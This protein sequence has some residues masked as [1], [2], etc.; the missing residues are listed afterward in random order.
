[1]KHALRQRLVGATS[2]GFRC[3]D[4]VRRVCRVE[5]WARALRE[6]RWKAG[7]AAL[8]EGT[9]IYPWVTIHNRDH[10]RIGARC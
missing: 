5:G 7:P 9:V 6:A 4:M 1:M 2:L 8:G 3:V 10:V